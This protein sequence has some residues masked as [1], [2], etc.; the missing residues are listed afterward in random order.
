LFFAGGGIRKLSGSAPEEELAGTE[1]EPGTGMLRRAVIAWATEIA[2]I[3]MEMHS[4]VF[5]RRAS[6]SDVVTA[7]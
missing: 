4:S 2:Q 3:E 6:G 1:L 5:D 7:C